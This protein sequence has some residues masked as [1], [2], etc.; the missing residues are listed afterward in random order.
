MIVIKK[1]CIYFGGPRLNARC[2]GDG[3]QTGR[4][5]MPK[6]RKYTAEDAALDL[7]KG[8]ANRSVTTEPEIII[9][10]QEVD[11]LIENFGF[12]KGAAVAA[13]YANFDQAYPDRVADWKEIER[14][15]LQ[16]KDDMGL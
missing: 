8:L 13:M 4:R 9:I 12:E 5:E 16:R 14:I 11:K 1:C 15:I 6:K 3:Q 2:R 7:V 10:A